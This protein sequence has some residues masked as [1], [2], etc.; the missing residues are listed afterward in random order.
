MDRKASD[1][2]I[3]I[4]VIRDGGRVKAGKLLRMGGVEPSDGGGRANWG[5]RAAQV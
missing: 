3:W 5:G 1:T 4:R 2:P